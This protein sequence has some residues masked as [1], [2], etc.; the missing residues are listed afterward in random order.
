MNF[1]YAADSCMIY[2]ICSAEHMVQFRDVA[3]RFLSS[4]IKTKAVEKGNAFIS[5]NNH[6]EG[7]WRK[8][9]LG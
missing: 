6:E 4:T 1:T 3:V 2:L 9:P 5:L 7:L 8:A